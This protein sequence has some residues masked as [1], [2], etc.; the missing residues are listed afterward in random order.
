MFAPLRTTHLAVALALAAPAWVTITAPPARAQA[1]AAA[2]RQLGTVKSVSGDSITITTA[3]GAPITVNIAPG[4]PVL[5]LPPGSTDLKTATPAA[6][7]DI[8]V[9]DR[10][11]ATGKPGDS[12]D[13]IVASRIILMKSS[14]LAA[15]NQAQQADWQ[16]RGVGGIVKSIDGQVITISS[17][18]NHQDPNHGRNHLPPLRGR[19]RE[20]SGCEGQ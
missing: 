3:A 11:L 15:R 7:S 9:G 4:A 20:V 16:R 13:V 6:A 8:A 19:F 10:I 1:P 2:S 12:A 17:C 18:T 14:D 5:Q